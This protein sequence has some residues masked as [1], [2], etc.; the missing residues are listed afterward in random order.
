[1]LQQY[2]SVGK[3]AERIRARWE[4]VGDVFV[5]IGWVQPED[6]NYE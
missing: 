5:D 1:M 2:G 4:L 3:H 6:D